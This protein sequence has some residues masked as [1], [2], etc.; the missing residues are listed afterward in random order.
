MRGIWVVMRRMRGIRVETSRMQG[1][2]MKIRDIRVEIKANRGGKA[3]N[4]VGNERNAG[5][6]GEEFEELGV[7]AGSQG[8]NVENWHKNVGIGSEMRYTTNGE[9]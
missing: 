5:N 1:I 2:R 6:Q 9:G 8:R 3:G 4:Q 7:N